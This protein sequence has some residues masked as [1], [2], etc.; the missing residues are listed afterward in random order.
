M[1]L[2]K[3]NV[4]VQML[5]DTI[6]KIDKL[7]TGLKTTNRSEIVKTSVDIADMV[8]EVLKNKGRVILED[9]DGTKRQIVVP[10]V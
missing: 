10:G 4:Q 8:V 3:K 7:K 5:T 2:K 9:K 6:E 1:E